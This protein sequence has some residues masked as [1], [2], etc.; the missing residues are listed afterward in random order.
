MKREG[1]TSNSDEALADN[2]KALKSI[3]ASA[4]DDI[5]ALIMAKKAG[6]GN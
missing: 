4:S 2:I 5:A 6:L 1:L 3:K